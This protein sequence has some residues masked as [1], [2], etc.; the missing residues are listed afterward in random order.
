[1]VKK[2]D[3]NKLGAGDPSQIFRGFFQWTVDWSQNSR[4]I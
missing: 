3:V 4:N 2:E 1:L